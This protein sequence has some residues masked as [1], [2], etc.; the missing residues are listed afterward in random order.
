MAVNRRENIGNIAKQPGLGRFAIF[1]KRN[2]TH[3]IIQ[4]CLIEL[5]TKFSIPADGEDRPFLAFHPTV[6]F[7]DNLERIANIQKNP[8]HT[9]D[10]RSRCMGKK[11]LCKRSRKP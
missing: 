11:E 2:V 1:H 9:L 3:T 7:L 4:N 10:C 5:I 6:D 8:N